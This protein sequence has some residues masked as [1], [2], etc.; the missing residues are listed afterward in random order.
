MPDLITRANA[1]TYIARIIGGANDPKILDAADEFITSASQEW[2]NA[3][4]WNFLLRDT[5]LGFTV[6]TVTIPAADDATTH[7][8]VLTAPSVGAFDAI[9]IGIAITAIASVIADGT[10]VASYTRTADGSI[11]T[12]TLSL[13][14]LN[15]TEL[16]GDTAV[17]LTFSGDIPLIAGVNEYNLPLDIDK[18]YGLRLTSNKWPL[19]YCQYREWNRKVNDQTVR[20]TVELYTIFNPHSWLT[21]AR[22][23]KRL[24]V[25]RTPARADTIHMQY[26]RNMNEDA[27]P[28]DMY[29]YYLYSFLD[30]CRYLLLLS[31]NAHDDRLPQIETRAK[32]AMQNAMNDDDE[33]TE[34]EDLRMKSQQEMGNA[35]RPLWNNG[36][37]YPDYGF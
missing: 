12:I 9:N 5:S 36:P 15:A 29:P 22:A 26:Y 25:F 7:G 1:R 16:T 33:H 18:P 21:A 35:A 23:Q 17:T 6:A 30:Y 14:T 13:A 10:T 32:A 11:D 31:K 8:L 24:R 37:F 3:K 19:E 27:D 28:I 4:D 20:G 2:N 34:D